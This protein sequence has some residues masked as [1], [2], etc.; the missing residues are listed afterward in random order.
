MTTGDGYDYS[1]FSSQT[2]EKLE[3]LAAVIAGGEGTQTRSGVSN[4]LALLEAKEVFG[5][6]R[7][8]LQWCDAALRYKPRKA[9][10]Y[11]NAARLFQAYGDDVYRLQ[12]TSAEDLGSSSVDPAVVQEVFVRLRRGEQITV[13]WVKEAIRRSGGDTTMAQEPI[14]DHSERMAVIIIEALDL[15]ECELLRTFI[16][17]RPSARMFMR[18]LSDR[19]AAKIGG[20]RATWATPLTA[21]PP[22]A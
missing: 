17:E 19:A 21:S 5:K 12:L 8:F 11:M 15:S 16:E 20:S 3:R 14:N 9:Q 7:A 2:R 10:R 1:V 18:D 22:A 13:E 4:G 6:K